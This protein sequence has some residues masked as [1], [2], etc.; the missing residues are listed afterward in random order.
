MECK[1]H[2]VN[3]VKF[4]VFTMA[5]NQEILTDE[6]FS[7][8]N[9][10][11]Q[12]FL[13]Q[14]QLCENSSDNNSDAS[15]ILRTPG[16]HSDHVDSLIV[17]QEMAKETEIEIEQPKFIFKKAQSKTQFECPFCEKPYLGVTQL[18]KHV[19]SQHKAQKLD[20]KYETLDD[21]KEKCLLKL[22]KPSKKTHFFV[23]NVTL[24]LTPP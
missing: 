4:I 5:N 24:A 23:T 17:D 2:I 10:F 11:L 14:T 16:Y 12:K 13:G 22:G 1:A 21:P 19:K 18:K 3:S 20:Q 8:L 15:H 6:Q 7:D 9:S